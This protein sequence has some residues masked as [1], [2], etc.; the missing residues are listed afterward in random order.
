L[1]SRNIVT[2]G[3]RRLVR[4]SP[5][6]SSAKAGTTTRIPGMPVSQPSMFWLWYSPPPM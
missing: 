6:A 4:S 2:P 5:A 1:G 3:E